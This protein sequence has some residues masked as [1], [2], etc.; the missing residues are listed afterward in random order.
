MVVTLTGENSFGLGQELRRLINDFVAEQ[1]DLALEKLDGDDVE[2]DR[3]REA[4]TS[5]P[6]LASKKMVVLHSPSKN[7][8]FLES[9]EQIL[10][11]M[12]ETTEVVIL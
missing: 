4:L 9:C 6:F 12:P 5:L 7:K 3:L 2:F 10:E 11:Q 1:G 8:Q